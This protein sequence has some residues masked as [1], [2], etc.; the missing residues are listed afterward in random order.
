MP[1]SLTL[2][3]LLV[4]SFSR[5]APLHSLVAEGANK[6]RLSRLVSARKTRPYSG[7]GYRSTGKNPAAEGPQSASVVIRKGGRRLHNVPFRLY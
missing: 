2:Y 5:A 3:L 7:E 1:K 6:R 4:A